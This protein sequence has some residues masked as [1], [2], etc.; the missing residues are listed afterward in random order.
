MQPT[1]ARWPMVTAAV[2]LLI[3]TPIAVWWLVGD[4]TEIPLDENPDYLLRAIEV[5]PVLEDVVGAASALTAGV[6]LLF[7]T[8]VTIRHPSHRPW[9]SVVLP[10]VVIG[11][12]LGVGYRAL[13]MGTIGANI[14]AGVFVWWGSPAVAMLLMWAVVRSVELLREERRLVRPTRRNST[15]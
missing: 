3:A 4:Q 5:D 6:A 9:W 1:M 7:T 10:V 15:R 13:T 2:S 14:G 12:I 8:W 11:Y